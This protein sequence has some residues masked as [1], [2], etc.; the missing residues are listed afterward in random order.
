[1]T[2]FPTIDV[3]A[4]VLTEETMARM[5]AESAAFAP[6]LEAVAEDHA[7]LVTGASRYRPF[8][9]GAWDV[10]RRLRDMARARVDVQLLSV[11]PQTYGYDLEPALA[12]A[13]ARIQNEAIAGLVRARPD[14]FLGLATL[15]MQDPDAAALELR[16]SMTSLGLKGAAVCTNVGQKNLD[17][18]DLD[19]VWQAADDLGAFV[20]VHPQ[21]PA[22]AERLAS[23]YLVNLIGNPLETTIAVA[24][25]V[26]GGVVE[27]F[28]R[29]NFCF[30]HGGG[31]AP[32]QRGRFEHGWRVRAEP[33]SRLAG[34][35]ADSLSRLYFDTI[36]HARG[37]LDFL[38]REAGA[39]RVLIGTDYPFDMGSETPVTEVEALG[40]STPACHA[41]CGGTAARV[42]GVRS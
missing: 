40:L 17:A 36:L 33:R 23:Y 42:L 19:P 38:V 7:V 15:P 2:R 39:E 26:F 32:Y 5:R 16:R 14:R 30:A 6:R 35:P 3:H 11:C 8:P 34:R 10:E 12:A 4:H 13:F 28:P 24:S 22:G 20:F 21:R 9:R 25:L 18:P 1:M 29:I 31:F 27:R 41:I 37:A